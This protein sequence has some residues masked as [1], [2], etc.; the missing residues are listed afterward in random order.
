M[1]PNRATLKR[2]AKLRKK[3]RGWY[4][5]NCM[6]SRQKTIAKVVIG[7]LIVGIGVAVGVSISQAVGGT[8][9]KGAN[10]TAP[11]AKLPSSS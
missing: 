8:W 7:L 10:Q 11:V 4:P 5:W 3:L 1:W 6:T 2:E 9:F